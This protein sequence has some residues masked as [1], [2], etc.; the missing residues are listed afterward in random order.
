MESLD[1]LEYCKISHY[2]ITRK[3]SGR[4]KYREY[5]INVSKQIKCSFVHYF[6]MIWFKCNS[7]ILL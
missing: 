7:T 6:K 3:A 4:G 1:I 2:K 5:L